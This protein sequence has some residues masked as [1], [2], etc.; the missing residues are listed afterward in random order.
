M[1]VSLAG[2]D[3]MF[4]RTRTKSTGAQL[5][6]LER[7]EAARRGQ[8]SKQPDPSPRYFRRACRCR[9]VSPP[10]VLDELI[11]QWARM[12]RVLAGPYWGRAKRSSSSFAVRRESGGA[13]R[14]AEIPTSPVRSWFL[15]R[16][17]ADLV[18]LALCRAARRCALVL[19]GVLWLCLL[20][21]SD[22]AD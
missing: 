11:R 19:S 13:V 3:T 9:G 15:I 21:T 10:T 17:R 8:D 18:S 6:M 2:G 16:A 12:V 20:Y 14:S 5:I 1:A 4:P 7:R 22:A